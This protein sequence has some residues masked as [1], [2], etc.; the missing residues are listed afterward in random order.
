MRARERGE[1]RKRSAISKPLPDLLQMIKWFKIWDW[2]PIGSA[3]SDASINFE[4][5]TY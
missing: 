5:L 2:S 4:N 3:K 1:G